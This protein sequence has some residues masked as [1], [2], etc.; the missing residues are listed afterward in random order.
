MFGKDGRAEGKRLY[1]LAMMMIALGVKMK[2]DG[3]LC[4]VP[5]S[6]MRINGCCDSSG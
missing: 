1:Q 3:P 5:H 6:C 4:L 2:Q